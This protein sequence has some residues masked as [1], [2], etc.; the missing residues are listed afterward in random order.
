M[1]RSADYSRKVELPF[2]AEVLMAL[3]CIG[4]TFLYFRNL[5]LPMGAL[6]LFGVLVLRR[7]A[8][9]LSAAVL[10]AL[11]V[12]LFHAQRTRELQIVM[13]LLAVGMLLQLLAAFWQRRQLGYWGSSYTENAIFAMIGLI[14]GYGIQFRLCQ[15]AVGELDATGLRYLWMSLV[16]CTAAVA[17]EPV[18]TFTP[19]AGDPTQMVVLNPGMEEM[20][21]QLLMALTL[22]CFR[23]VLLLPSTWAILLA[24][25][26][27]S[28]LAIWNPLRVLYHAFRAFLGVQ[29]MGI[30]ATIIAFALGA[31]SIFLLMTGVTSFQVF[32][33][34]AMVVTFLLAAIAGAAWGAGRGSRSA[35]GK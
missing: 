3:I 23:L 19:G 7:N 13:V 34:L 22:V 8:W 30:L 24:G 14:I 28:G 25:L 16:S 31:A 17:M 6:L 12:D 18:G 20:S 29:V 35:S 26:R 10:M 4:A 1:S 9:A 33:D 21:P 5:L 2:F 11:A 15:P 32:L 27:A